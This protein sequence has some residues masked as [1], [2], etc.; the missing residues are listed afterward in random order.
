V[1]ERGLAV[2]NETPWENARNTT[3]AP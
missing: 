3:P 2:L 1:A